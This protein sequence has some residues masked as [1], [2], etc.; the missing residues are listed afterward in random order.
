VLDG[1]LGDIRLVQVEY[2]QDWLTEPLE[3]TGHKQAVWRSDPKRFYSTEAIAGKV[4]QQRC[5]PKAGT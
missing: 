1:E 3:S 5:G 4:R 2:A